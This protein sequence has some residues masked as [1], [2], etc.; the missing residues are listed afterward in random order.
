MTDKP[1]VATTSLCG[2]FGCHMSLLD[3]DER[4]LQL[5]QLVR[6][7]R[8]PLTDIK[9]IGECDLGLIEGGVANAENVEVLREFRRHC[10]VLV[11]VGACAVNGGIPAMRN[12]F[13]LKECLEESYVG[14]V[15][16]HN[17][18]I[19]N[20]PEIPLLLNQV[21]PIHEVV[22]VDYFLPGCPPSADTLW[23][24]LTELLAGQPIAF[25][26]TQ[27]HYD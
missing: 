12:Q 8:T 25:P 6:F 22:K 2:C 10:K 9:T 13:T 11:A 23:T 14:G 21:H 18:G 5:V 26:Y 16:V 27:I 7:D 3:I 17:P 15:G 24:F 20:D 19:P 1:R 4:I